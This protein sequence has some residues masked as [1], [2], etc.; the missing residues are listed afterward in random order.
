MYFYVTFQKLSRH[1]QLNSDQ[2]LAK[3]R[4]LRPLLEGLGPGYIPCLHSKVSFCSQGDRQGS[5]STNQCPEELAHLLGANEEPWGVHVYAGSTKPRQHF[6]LAEDVATDLLYLHQSNQSMVHA[7]HKPSKILLGPNFESCLVNYVLIPSL[8]PRP[9]RTLLCS[10][11]ALLHPLLGLGG[12]A[13]RRH[14]SWVYSMQEE[15]NDSDE[16]LGSFK[17][18]IALL[19]IVVACVA[20]EVEKQPLMREVLWMIREARVEVMALSNS[21]DHSLVRCSNTVQS[22]LREHDGHSTF[23]IWTNAFED[24]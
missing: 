22:L 4:C 10:S 19:N 21:Y 8:L 20:I 3:K 16:D 1:G 2:G 17:K 24:S 15:R 18:L 6:S 23:A 14:P 12:G 13:R 7:N 11:Q 5:R 9:H